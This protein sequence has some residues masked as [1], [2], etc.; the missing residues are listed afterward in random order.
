MRYDFTVTAVQM[1]KHEN[2]LSIYATTVNQFTT[3]ITQ[4]I[5]DKS[6]SAKDNMHGQVAGVANGECETA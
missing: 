5:L 4:L 3:N 1:T 6:M 2:D